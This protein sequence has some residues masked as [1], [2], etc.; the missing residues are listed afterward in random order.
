MPITVPNLD[1]RNF[2]DLYQEVRARVPVHSP[3][4]TNLNE[5]DPGVTLL[6]LFTFLAD[7]L[8]YRSNRIPE[9]TRRAFL[10]LLG[11]GL[12]PATPAA[13]FVTFTT[14]AEPSTVAAG[15]VVRAGK[16][17]YRTR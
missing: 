11:M 17:A 14:D 10:T 9:A 15:T 6:Q 8:T 3:E 13:G 7:N 4:W 16:V 2:D 1:D 12:Q 5:G